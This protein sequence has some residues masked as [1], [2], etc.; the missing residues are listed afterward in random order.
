MGSRILSIYSTILGRISLPHLPS[1]HLLTHGTDYTPKFNASLLPQ[2]I[3]LWTT[4][5]IT[6]Q[7]INSPEPKVFFSCWFLQGLEGLIHQQA[8]AASSTIKGIKGPKG[9]KKPAPC[10]YPSSHPY[11]APQ[12][13]RLRLRYFP[14]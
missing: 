7:E 1:S 13:R 5:G 3:E 6:L 9:R 2:A 11:R 12:Q 8:V 14:N 4:E 10:A